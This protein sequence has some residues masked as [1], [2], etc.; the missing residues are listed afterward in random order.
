MPKTLMLILL[1]CTC[2][3]ASFGKSAAGDWEA[4]QQDIPTG[5]PITVVTSMT[6][7]CIYESANGQELVCK[8][9]D[10]ANANDSEIH[11]RRERVHEI[12]VEKRQGANMLAGGAAGAGLGSI[13]GSLLIPGARGTSAYALGLGAASIGARSGRD[14]HILRGK[15]IYRRP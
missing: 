2:A 10:R 14:T 7:P 13:L 12:R 11:I 6:F 15:V 3:T 4:V 8:R 5:W 1:I 9:L